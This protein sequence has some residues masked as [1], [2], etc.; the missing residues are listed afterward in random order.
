MEVREAADGNEAEKLCHN[1]FR[2]KVRACALFK[3]IAIKAYPSGAPALLHV[4]A[5]SRFQPATYKMLIAPEA[6]A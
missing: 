1:S 6:T 2:L 3:C 5:W 4:V